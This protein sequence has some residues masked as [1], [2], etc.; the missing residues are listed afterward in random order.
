[1]K[2]LLFKYKSFILYVFFGVITTLI[3]WSSYYFCYCLIGIPNVVSTIIAWLLAVAF[4]FITNKKW[5]FNSESFEV[6]TLFY[7]IWTFVVARL[8]TGVLDVAIMFVAV[9]VLGWN[10]TIWKL[11]SNFIVIVIN[12]ILSKFIIFKNG[13]SQKH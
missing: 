11:I 10:A 2:E 3:N 13:N 7:E 1:M 6:K 5:V 8:V 12:Y 4:A 9:D